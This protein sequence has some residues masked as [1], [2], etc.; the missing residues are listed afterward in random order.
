MSQKVQFENIR[1]LV[2]EITTPSREIADTNTQ[3]REILE[4]VFDAGSDS[5]LDFDEVRKAIKLLYKSEKLNGQVEGL[6]SSLITGIQRL[7]DL[8]EQ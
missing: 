6:E 4:A 8:K 3:A 7:F 2:R 5:Y 1:H